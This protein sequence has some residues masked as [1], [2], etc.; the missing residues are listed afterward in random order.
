MKPRVEFGLLF[1]L[2]ALCLTAVAT[3]AYPLPVGP[4]WDLESFVGPVLARLAPWGWALL[5]F[6]VGLALGWWLCWWMVKAR[7]PNVQLK[8]PISRRLRPP[9]KGP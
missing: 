7:N 3:Q 1:F 4:V 8:A 2:T 9:R 6:L 5:A